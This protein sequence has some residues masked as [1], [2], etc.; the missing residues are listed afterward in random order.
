M[1]GA[2]QGA[3]PLF[4][5][6][7]E[8]SC[9]DGT[10]TSWTQLWIA[11]STNAPLPANLLKLDF[12]LSLSQPPV[13]LV[14]PRHVRSCPGWDMRARVKLDLALGNIYCFSRVCCVRCTLLPAVVI[15]GSQLQHDVSCCSCV[16]S[17][18]VRFATGP[19]LRIWC[20]PWCYDPGKNCGIRGWIP[21]APS[22]R[23]L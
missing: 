20:G 7:T 6:W 5:L 18:A 12:G 2:A 13:C 9:L 16:H 11:N 15:S 22:G 19:C 21:L 1:C 17:T 23:S 8:R 10:T 14:S 4:P 3:A